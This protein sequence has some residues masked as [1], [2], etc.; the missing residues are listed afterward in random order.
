MG[1]W[2]LRK[3]ELLGENGHTQ[4]VLAPCP[5]LVGSQ[6]CDANPTPLAI[7]FYLFHSLLSHLSLQLQSPLPLP[8]AL[9]S[10]AAL[11]A[12]DTPL[13]V[14]LKMEG[15]SVGGGGFPTATCLP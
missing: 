9:S 11:L 8:S 5:S 15:L 10:D 4:I 7:P 6:G 13:P 2:T 1:S 12:A 3:L 14:L